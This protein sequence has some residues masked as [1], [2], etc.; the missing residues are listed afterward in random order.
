M[1]KYVPV[2]KFFDNLRTG[3]IHYC[4]MG[5]EFMVNKYIMEQ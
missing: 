4:N 5:F 3:I 1:Y 2:R